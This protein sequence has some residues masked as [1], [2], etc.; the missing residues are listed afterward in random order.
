MQTAIQLYTLRDL[1]E[2]LTRTLERI[3]ETP[4]DGAEFGLGEESAEDVAETLEE[5]GLGISSLG[6]G[7]DDLENPQENLVDDC[8]TLGCDRVLLAYLDETHFE[9]R[10]AAKETADMVSG[11]VENVASTDLD[12]VYHNHAHEFTDVGDGET[13]FDVFVEHVDDRLEFELDLGWIGT[14]GEDPE[15]WLTRLG[16]RT[17]VVH[18]KDMHFEEGTFAD[19]GEGDLDVEAGLR[20]AVEQD[21]EWAVYEHDEPDDPLEALHRDGQILVDAVKAAQNQ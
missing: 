3:A 1:D 10:A 4:L 19:L 20:T 9:S 16:D 6:V 14:G 15:E 2:P 18:I 8:R 11:F 21:V 7:L 5:T 13:A 12:L 17:P